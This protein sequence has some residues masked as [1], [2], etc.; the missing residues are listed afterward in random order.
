V[1]QLK[2]GFRAKKESYHA[3]F[4]SQLRFYNRLNEADQHKFLTRTF[5]FEQSKQFHFIDLPE[6]PEKT[7]LISAIAVQLTF[8][9]EKYKLNYFHN[10]FILR[11]DYHYSDFSYRLEGHVD[12]TGIYLS[13]DRFIKA[14]NGN[15]RNSNIGL[16]EMGHAL[17]YVN[18]IT[19]TEKDP[20]FQKE[21]VQ[22]SLVARPVFELLESK[23][24]SIFSDYARTNYQEFWANCVEL[25]FENPLRLRHE[26]PDL[27]LSLKRLLRQDPLVILNEE[28][29]AA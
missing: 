22:F 11:D 1:V 26:F 16:H 13:W 5:I 10:I 7:A 19:R 29:L 2:W 15:I 3:I 20:H 18:F 9:L 6:T 14:L 21:F 8:G 4:S 28:R 27:Y 24:Q 17:T 12:H 25:F 23:R